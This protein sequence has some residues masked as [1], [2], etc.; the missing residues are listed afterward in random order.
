VLADPEFPNAVTL[1]AVLLHAA[2]SR[3]E[4]I[5]VTDLGLATLARLDAGLDAAVA[6]GRRANLLVLRLGPLEDLGRLEEALADVKEVQRLRA[7]S[8]SDPDLPLVDAIRRL[9]ESQQAADLAAAV[10][11]LDFGDQAVGEAERLLVEAERE[12][13]S[14]AFASVRVKV[15]SAR[16]DLLARRAE[17]AGSGAER[18]RLLAEALRSYRSALALAERLGATGDV[19]GLSAQTLAELRRATAALEARL[20]P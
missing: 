15:E 6:A 14:G 5:A 1:A 18:R 10:G 4:A 13:G 16:G 7:L 8:P 2:G 3:E 11:D 19:H 20:R 17:R 9:S 12:F